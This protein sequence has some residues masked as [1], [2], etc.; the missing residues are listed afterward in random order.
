MQLE[1]HNLQSLILCAMHLVGGEERTLFV[2]LAGTVLS[3]EIL[4]CR[5]KGLGQIL[6]EETCKVRHCCIKGF[7]K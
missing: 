7:G 2:K 4:C 3:N 5:V 1:L 6:A